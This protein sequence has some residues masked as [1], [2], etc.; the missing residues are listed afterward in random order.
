MAFA[1]SSSTTDCVRNVPS[2]RQRMRF[3]QSPFFAGSVSI[4]AGAQAASRCSA[5]DAAA[6]HEASG[7]CGGDNSF[8]NTVSADF[9]SSFIAFLLQRKKNKIIEFSEFVLPPPDGLSC[10]VVLGRNPTASAP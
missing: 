10:K 6:N 8:S 4:S 2:C 9:A 3:A 5:A 7:T 1:R